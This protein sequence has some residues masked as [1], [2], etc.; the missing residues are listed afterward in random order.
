M[1]QEIKQYQADY[2]LK[3]FIF[4]VVNQEIDEIS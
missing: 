2:D 3:W 4:E 1:H